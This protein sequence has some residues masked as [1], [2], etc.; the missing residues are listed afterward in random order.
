VI[1]RLGEARTVLLDKTG[2]VTLGLPSVGRVVAFDGIAPSELLRLAASVDQLSAHVLAEA[3]VH[4]AENKGLALAAPERVEEG[5]GQGVEGV[6][7]GHRS[8]APCVQGP[9]C[10]R[11]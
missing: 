2:T 6:V 8:S 4:D 5:R 9:N 7:D 1:E 11:S 10:A 3:L